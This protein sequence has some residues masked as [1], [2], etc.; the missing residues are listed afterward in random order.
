M[1]IYDRRTISRSTVITVLIVAVLVV[2]G[3]G[4]YHVRHTTAFVN[5]TSH[6]PERF[7][8]L[9]FNNPTKLPAIVTPGTKLPVSFTVHNVEARDMTYVY[10]VSFVANGR[11]LVSQQKGFNLTSNGT[12][13]ITSN[14]TVPSF[15]GKAEVQVLLNNVGQSI[16]FWVITR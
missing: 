13:T 7:T 1:S 6:R 16:H 5:A 2:L 9:Y 12:N 11:T 15:S 3:L 8:E 4:L 14:I 10:T